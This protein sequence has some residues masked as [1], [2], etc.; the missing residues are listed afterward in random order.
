[1]PSLADEQASRRIGRQATSTI[2]LFYRLFKGCCHFVIRQA[3]YRLQATVQFA[4]EFFASFALKTKKNC[5]DRKAAGKGP[6]NKRRFN[7]Q[8]AT[9]NYSLHC[10]L[11]SCLVLSRFF[12]A[13]LISWHLV[14]GKNPLLLV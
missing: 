9:T 12:A 11:F 3:P 1:M 5:K 7:F 8:T 4:F 13:I 6:Q 14:C 10:F 2:L